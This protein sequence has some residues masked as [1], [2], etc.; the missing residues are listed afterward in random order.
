LVPG[1]SQPKKKKIV[2]AVRARY[3]G[4][5]NG[6]TPRG[7][8]NLTKRMAKGWGQGKGAPCQSS[9]PGTTDNQQ[10]SI[11]TQRGVNAPEIGKET[12]GEGRELYCKRLLSET[13]SPFKL[14]IRKKEGKKGPQR[15]S[16]DSES[17]KKKEIY[18]LIKKNWALQPA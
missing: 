5:G 6:S 16:T 14:S 12:S 9:S 15:V 4:G 18:H 17:Q 1:E 7:K 11:E 10:T 8:R 13:S 2:E 3:G